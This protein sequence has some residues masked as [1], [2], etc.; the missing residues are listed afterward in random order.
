M[1]QKSGGDKVT[2]YIVIGMVTLVVA[3]GVIFSLVGNKSSDSAS[4][5]SQASSTDGFGIS[6]NGDL[7]GVPVLDIWED[8]QCPACA[9]FEAL[10]SA[11][12]ENIIKEKKATVIFHP[13][14]FIGPESIRAANAAACAA[15][16]GKYLEY[17]DFLYRNQPAENSG[18]WSNAYL[19]AGGVA[20]GI[21][22]GEFGACINDSKY[23]GWV[24]NIAVDG[25]KQ[26]INSTPTVFLNGKELDRNTQIYDAAAFAAAIEQG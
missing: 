1:A 7:T 24:K 11:Y 18:K 17:H 3:V 23:G 21:S 25:G 26:N 13:L 12:I 9:Q 22:S 2:R 5:P 8:F 4:L 16:E 20:I 14:S 19:I 10:N 6:Y 15:D